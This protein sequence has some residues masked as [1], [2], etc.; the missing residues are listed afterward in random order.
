MPTQI[1]QYSD[2]PPTWTNNSVI[3]T[4]YYVV[5][6]LVLCPSVTIALG[7]RGQCP[8]SASVLVPLWPVALLWQS[9]M[10]Q[11]TGLCI[12]V[13]DLFAAFSVVRSSE[14]RHRLFQM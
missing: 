11:P 10:L 14:L 2:T 9:D 13:Y 4:K 1:A 8:P 6:Q 5:C 3:C 12:N 7:V